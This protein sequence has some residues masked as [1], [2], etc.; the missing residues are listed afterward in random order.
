MQFK[1]S[2]VQPFGNRAPQFALAASTV[3][4]YTVPGTDEVT[5]QM[6]FS[7]PYNANVWVGLNATPVIPTPATMSS[8][9]VSVLNPHRKFV[10]GG[11]VLSFIS[12]S[13]VVNAGFELFEVGN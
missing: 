3:L 9:T 12:D 13:I 2:D 1:L 4:T 11:D 5:Y 6:Q 8:S 10:K 7:W